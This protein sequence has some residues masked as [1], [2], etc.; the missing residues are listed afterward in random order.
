MTYYK[1]VAENA[2]TFIKCPR[3]CRMSSFN[4]TQADIIDKNNE[5]KWT[6]ETGYS[7]NSTPFD[8]PWR[9][10]G[11]TV[12]NAVRVLFTLKNTN[13]EDHCP[14]S[15]SGLT[16]TKSFIRYLQYIVTA[17]LVSYTHIISL[18]SSSSLHDSNYYCRTYLKK[19]KKN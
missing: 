2:H 7:Q 18:S 4:H 13:S 6:P 16:V 15:D 3:A 17:L 11:D 1:R 5:T 9:V 8:V 14:K 12:E 10:T 19:K